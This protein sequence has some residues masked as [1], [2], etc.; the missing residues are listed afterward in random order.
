MVKKLPFVTFQLKSHSWKKK[1]K[2]FN[3]AA[4]ITKFLHVSPFVKTFYWLT[5]YTAHD[6]KC[7]HT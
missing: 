5:R 3:C 1:V 4:K 7:R 6:Y 2:I